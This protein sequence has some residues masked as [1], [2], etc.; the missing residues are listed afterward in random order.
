LGLYLWAHVPVDYHVSF[1]VSG[2]ECVGVMSL[3]PVLEAVRQLGMVRL[4]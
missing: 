2:F 1:L 3:A 4:A